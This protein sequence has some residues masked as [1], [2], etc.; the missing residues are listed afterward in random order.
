MVHDKATGL[1]KAS[2]QLRGQ[3]NQELL[4]KGRYIYRELPA[5]QGLAWD[6]PENRNNLGQTTKA[7]QPQIRHLSLP[8]HPYSL[9]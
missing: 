8:A 3:S 9:T 6:I 4:S 2:L 1:K 7:T 5:P